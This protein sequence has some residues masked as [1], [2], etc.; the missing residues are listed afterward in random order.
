MNDSVEGRL[1][2]EDG[3]LPRHGITNCDAG[4]SRVTIEA[5]GN[6]IPCMGLGRSFGSVAEASFSTAWR[7][8]KAQRYRSDASRPLPVC[9]EC[10]LAALCST[11]C[12]R[13][14]L[15]EHGDMS[16]PSQRAC[17]LAAIMADMRATRLLSVQ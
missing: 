1:I 13:L 15:L 5:D 6:V 7:S 2:R 12:P 17:E 10:D 14:A 16:A 9:E 8:E 11:R 4:I 3:D